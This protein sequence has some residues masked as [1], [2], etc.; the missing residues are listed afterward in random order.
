MRHRTR[1]ADSY[2]AGAHL[3][4]HCFVCAPPARRE[5]GSVFI[6]ALLALV[7]LTVIGLSL[8]L[9]TETEM[10]LGGNERI[11]TETFYAGETGVSVAVG[12]AMLGITDEKCF[13]ALAREEDGTARQVGVRNLG[14]SIDTTSLYPLSFDIA[15]YSKANEGRGDVLY[16]AFFRGDVRA[17]RGSWPAA[18][19]VPREPG[20]DLAAVDFTLQGEQTIDLAFFV[21]PIQSQIDIGAFD[22]P[23]VLGCEP[24]PDHSVVVAPP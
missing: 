18:D 14:Y 5:R 7:L 6:V 10:L 15:P 12:Q 22:H 4:E 1:A 8:A 21:T 11:I 17:L 19:A 9:V 3:V 13:A 16:S 23:D 24:H 2:P 20:E